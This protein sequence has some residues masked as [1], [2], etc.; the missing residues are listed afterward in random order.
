MNVIELAARAVAANGWR[1]M[2]G[3]ICFPPDHP[4]GSK[5]YWTYCARLHDPSDFSDNEP[6]PDYI[7]DLE[8]P[9]TLGCLLALVRKK[10]EI[11]SESGEYLYSH[12]GIHSF[13]RHVGDGWCVVSNGPTLR[14][15]S[16]GETEA[17]ALV[18]ALEAEPEGTA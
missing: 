4:P 6:P 15:L 5:H 17:E 8:D 18:N 3:M 1:W 2:G 11:P 10:H 12:P 7:P 14:H 13:H 9:A 16:C